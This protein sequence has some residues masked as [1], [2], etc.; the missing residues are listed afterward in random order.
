M[1][2]VSFPHFIASLCA[3]VG[4]WIGRAA[5]EGLLGDSA[6]MPEVC[7]A[8]VLHRYLFFLAC[9]HTSRLF[10]S[11]LVSRSRCMCSVHCAQAAKTTTTTPTAA[12]K[13]AAVRTPKDFAIGICS[14][15]LVGLFGGSIL[16]PL[17][18]AA[19]AAVRRRRGSGRARH[20]CLHFS[21]LHAPSCLV[22]SQHFLLRL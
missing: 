11:R 6:A 2:A 1:L 13:G 10:V 21:V 15:A 22:H 17:N 12:G 18:F 8:A 16:I 4:V 19:P 3:D 14:A 7:S 20:S 5:N 9:V